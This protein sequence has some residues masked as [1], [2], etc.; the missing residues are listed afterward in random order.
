MRLEIDFPQFNMDLYWAQHTHYQIIM[1]KQDAKF[2]NHDKMTVEITES[3]CTCCA[4]E[5]IQFPSWY[6]NL[7]TSRISG[8]GNIF[9]NAHVCVCLRSA[10]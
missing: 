6:H 8:R 3:Q 9:G 10:D 4:P 2:N 1:I 7:I 5:I